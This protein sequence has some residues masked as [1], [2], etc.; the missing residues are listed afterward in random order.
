MIHEVT[1][2]AHLAPV[3]MEK[4]SEGDMNSLWVND[5]DEDIFIEDDND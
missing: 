1:N 2:E 3:S 5:D 4:D